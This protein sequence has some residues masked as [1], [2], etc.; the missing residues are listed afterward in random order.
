MHRDGALLAALAPSQ[1]GPSG[2]A[3]FVQRENRIFALSRPDGLPDKVI[4]DDVVFVFGNYTDTGVDIAAIAP[5]GER[6]TVTGVQLSLAGARPTSVAMSG[7][8]NRGMDVP[9][10]TELRSLA[11]LI[12]FSVCAIQAG[13]AF[14]VGGV[15]GVALVW[16]TVLRACGSSVLLAFQAAVGLSPGLADAFDRA[17]T[18]AE[19][20]EYLVCTPVGLESCI[21]EVILRGVS[22]L[23]VLTQR[24]IIYDTI[25]AFLRENVIAGQVTNDQTFVPLAGARVE[26]LEPNRV[27]VLTDNQGQYAIMPFPSLPGNYTLRASKEGFATAQV[28]VRM[29]GRTSRD[30]ALA[31]APTCRFTGSA[32]IT[33]TT[34]YPGGEAP[35]VSCVYGAAMSIRGFEIVETDANVRVSPADRDLVGAFSLQT[36]PPDRCRGSF[37]LYMDTAMPGMTLVRRGDNYSGTTVMPFPATGATVTEN[38]IQLRFTRRPENLP[39]DYSLRL[40]TVQRFDGPGIVPYRVE[41]QW[42]AEAS[43][44][45]PSSCLRAQT[46]R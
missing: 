9:A 29:N 16:P 43:F 35:N 2:G 31:Q 30:V 8:A 15:A 23:E 40:S 11:T 20:L 19:F 3:A 36:G 4:I 38:Q 5:N 17:E 37:G 41:R 39:G 33:D 26:I 14:A 7:S 12:N 45:L 27:S 10:Q 25:E 32:T 42:R 24:P 18:S 21:V 44:S 13:G 28:S 6:Q 34:V 22:I 1:I 46:D